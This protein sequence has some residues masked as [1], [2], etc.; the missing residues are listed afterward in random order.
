MSG[1]EHGTQ[2]GYDRHIQMGGHPCP[3]CRKAAATRRRELES[4]EPERI[5]SAIPSHGTRAGALAHRARGEKPCEP[6]R[7]AANDY[8]RPRLKARNRAA[9][10]LISEHRTRFEELLAEELRRLS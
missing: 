2:E 10:R 3:R 4:R 6:C 5:H 1:F 9:S 8:N 7:A